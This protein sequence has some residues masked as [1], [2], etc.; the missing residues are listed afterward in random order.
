MQYRRLT[1]VLFFTLLLPGLPS[2]VATDIK[3]PP[4]AGKTEELTLEKHFPKKGLFGRPGDDMA[5]SFDSK[6]AAY[7]YRSHDEERQG[8]DLWLLDVATKKTTRITSKVKMARYQ[9]SART[10]TDKT[11]RS[12]GV[13]SF[14]WSP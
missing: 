4:P 10:A 13:S 2:L 5:F 11:G 8:P 9:T 1:A 14:T 3:A 7:R 6:Y 12:S